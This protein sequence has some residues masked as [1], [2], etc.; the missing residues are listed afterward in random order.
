[1]IANL[2]NPPQTEL[3]DPSAYPQLGLL[4]LG[5]VLEKNGIKCKYIDLSDKE[6]Y[7]VPEADAHLITVVTA[8]Y[9]SALEVTASIDGYKVVGGFHP[10]IYPKDFKDVD[11]IVMGEGESI[12]TDIVKNK[13]EGTFKAEPIQELDSIPFPA[14]H[15][16]PVEKLRNLGGIHGDTYKGDGASTTILSSRGCPYRCSFCSKY[17]A[18]TRYFRWRSAKNVRDEIREIQE[19]YDIH[20]FRFVDDCFTVNKKRIYELCKMIKPLD[21]YW[22]CITRTD[23]VDRNILTAMYDAGCREIQFG[24]ETGSQRLLDL[25]NKQTTVQINERACLL[26]K[27]IGLKV[28]VLLMHN[29]PS[30]TDDDIESTKVFVR[31]VK[32]D[33]WTLSKFVPLPGSE[34][35]N[36]WE[37]YGIDKPSLRNLWYY[38]DEDCEL[39][40]WLIEGDWRND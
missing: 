17:L 30:E 25:L 19:E 21:V 27:G 16:I 33:K 8:T 36:N 2:I 31:R 5:A 18:Q 40:N 28:K 10:S 35:W 24:I 26:A 11:A 29:I 39:K 14:R 34:I 1:M 4:Y 12:I 13:R 3:Y 22:L 20:H 15:L 23:M 6:D 32:P 9:K 37:K 7:D 38:P